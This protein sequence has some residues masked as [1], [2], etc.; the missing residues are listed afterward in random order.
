MKNIIFGLLLILFLVASVYGAKY[1]YDEFN[2]AGERITQETNLKENNEIKTDD[3]DTAK[4][5][6]Y[7]IVHGESPIDN[8]AKVAIEEL[9]QNY[10]E[11]IQPKDDIFAVYFAQIV[12]LTEKILIADIVFKDKS[13][14]QSP[15]TSPYDVMF[16]I[17]GVFNNGK[18]EMAM[19]GTE[20]MKKLKMKY[21][22]INWDTDVRDKLE[23]KIG[24]PID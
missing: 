6:K 11:S 15:D 7:K 4:K 23:Y 2:K 5:P 3:I 22:K 20:E 9:L 8:T 13:K 12:N 17:V 24:V 1:Y 10:N 21:S 16:Q 19:Q 14:P 18:W